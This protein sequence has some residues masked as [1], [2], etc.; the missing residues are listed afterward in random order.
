VIH[1]R[2]RGLFEPSRRTLFLVPPHRTLARRTTPKITEQLNTNSARIRCP[3]CNWQ[4][5]REDT[6][7]C[8]PG[9]GHVWNT[10]ETRGLCP[11]CSKQWTSTACLRCHEWSPHDDW[12]EHETQP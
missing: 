4:P 5:K 12:Y 9:C 1:A 11:G 7:V 6:W 3:K 8:A 2:E 10:F